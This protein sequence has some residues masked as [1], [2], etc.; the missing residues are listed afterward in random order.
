MPDRTIYW[1]GHPLEQ[2]P[3]PLRMNLLLQQRAKLPF[4]IWRAMELLFSKAGDELGP[5]DLQRSIDA[6]G[7]EAEHWH[8]NLPIA[9]QEAFDMPSPLFQFQ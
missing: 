5:L 4:Y 1:T 3:R 8:S 7:S 9:L 6:L 2:Q